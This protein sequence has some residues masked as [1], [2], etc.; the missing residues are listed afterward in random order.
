MN[1]D[2][3]SKEERQKLYNSLFEVSCRQP[4]KEKDNFLIQIMK[5]AIEDHFTIF[6]KNIHSNSIYW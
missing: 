4:V 6:L 5:K 3:L 1:I 2:M